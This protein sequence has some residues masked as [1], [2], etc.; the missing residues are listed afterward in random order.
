MFGGRVLRFEDGCERRALVER[1]PPRPPD[2]ELVAPP[3][4]CSV[5]VPFDGVA[6]A[7]I[8][9]V[10]P[11][12]PTISDPYRGFTP[13]CKGGVGSTLLACGAAKCPDPLVLLW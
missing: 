8:S 9:I 11:G 2:E 5:C 12:V 1:D 6:V 7:A 13:G 4:S 10:V 3:P